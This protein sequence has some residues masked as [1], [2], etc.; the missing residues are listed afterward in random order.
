M[1]T[2]LSPYI[3]G[4]L[5]M[6]NGRNGRIKVSTLNKEE[7]RIRI[8]IVSKFSWKI[9]SNAWNKENKIIWFDNLHIDYIQCY[10]K[11]EPDSYRLMQISFLGT[12]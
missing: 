3:K 11:N 1:V 4:Y 5:G 12:I 8:P 2:Y 7:K 6:L 10:N 9:K